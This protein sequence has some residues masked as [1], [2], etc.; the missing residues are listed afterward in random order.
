MAMNVTFKIQGEGETQKKLAEL[1]E[2]IKVVNS[3]LHKL[4]RMCDSLNPL[5]L[6]GEVDMAEDEK[7]AH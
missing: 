6:R 5:S 1:D 3:E 4:V 2:Q 7:D